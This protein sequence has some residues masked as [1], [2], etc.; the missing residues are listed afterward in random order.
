MQLEAI[1]KD[2]GPSVE[3]GTVARDKTLAAILAE[4]KAA[5]EEQFANVWKSMKQG[6]QHLSFLMTC[7]KSLLPR[8]TTLPRARVHRSTVA[9][10]CKVYRALKDM[11][12]V[13]KEGIAFLSL[14][15][16]HDREKSA[17]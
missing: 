10:L 14:N 15:I 5:K 13:E 3:D 8:K 11:S 1:K 7:C 12:V 17:A 2:R 9:S 4:N 16:L 6:L